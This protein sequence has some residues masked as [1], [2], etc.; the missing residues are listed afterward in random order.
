MEWMPPLVAVIGRV[1]M[2]GNLNAGLS[3]INFE[4]V[5]GP[6][7]QRLHLHHKSRRFPGPNI[8]TL[9]YAKRFMT[10]SFVFCSKIPQSQLL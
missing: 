3:R 2:G 7:T 9:G 5:A 4:I 10:A 8:L 6:T 1:P